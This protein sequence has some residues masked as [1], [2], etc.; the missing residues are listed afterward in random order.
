MDEWTFK[1]THESIVTRLERCH[2]NIDVECIVAPNLANVALCLLSRLEKI[3]PLPC[4]SALATM[5]VSPTIPYPDLVSILSSSIEHPLE[6]YLVVLSQTRGLEYKR[7]ITIKSR[8]WTECSREEETWAKEGLKREKTLEPK[9]KETLRTKEE[10]QRLNGVLI[11]LYRDGSMRWD[12]Y[13]STHGNAF[14]N[15][16]DGEKLWCL[17]YSDVCLFD[18]QKRRAGSSEEGFS[19]FPFWVIEFNKAHSR[20]SGRFEETEYKEVASPSALN[21]VITWHKKPV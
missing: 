10:T 14:P 17:S 8:R 18:I 3:D 9:A 7:N 12:V 21:L 2:T 16:V 19:S 11:S 20:Q 4:P 6:P 13:R 1:P 5:F 15:L